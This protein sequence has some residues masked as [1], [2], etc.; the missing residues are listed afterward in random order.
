M[1]FA[2][3]FSA[4]QAVGAQLQ[5]IEPLEPPVL[6]LGSA[7]PM[8]QVLYVTLKNVGEEAVSESRL[9]AH[10]DQLVSAI[11]EPI[12]CAASQAVMCS[13]LLLPGDGLTVGDPVSIHVDL[14]DG[15]GQRTR[16]GSA[17]T[18]T[19]LC[20][21]LLC[22]RSAASADDFFIVQVS[23]PHIIKHDSTP[24]NVK[25]AD[26]LEQAVSEINA[27]NPA[28]DFV[29][30]TGD[31]LL[32]NAV[33]YPLYEEIISTLNVPWL[34]AFGNHDKPAGLAH[35][36][37][38]FSEW[39]HSE[40]YAF[41]HKGYWF[42]VLDGVQDIRPNFAEFTPTQLQWLQVLLEQTTM[43]RPQTFFLHHDLFSGR[44]VKDI[45]PAQAVLER[46]ETEKWFFS[47]HWHADCFVRR[48]TQRHIVTTSIGYLFGTPRLAH[49]RGVPGYRLIH[50][51]QGNIL[52]QFK[53][54]GGEVLSDPPSEEYLSPSEV[55]KALDK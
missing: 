10:S 46:F 17:E 5:V 36:A 53:P 18:T 48:G 11:S 54:L 27:M 16:L 13:V 25:T 28:P 9:I 12:V 51:R 32:D 7:L 55:E 41:V 2:V 8:R 43:D 1:L 24:G 23:D 4:Y 26:R 44:G 39:G 3:V 52:T 21:P 37:R 42:F 30:V 20:H 29:V 50:Y 22:Q 6:L 38:V 19:A 33:G 31:I 40:Y 14:L 47:G 34:T 15:E 35:A 45:A 49:D